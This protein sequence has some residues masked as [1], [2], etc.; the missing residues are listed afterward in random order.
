[1]LDSISKKFSMFL[2]VYVNISKINH[3]LTSFV[4]VSPTVWSFFPT[5]FSAW[6][7]FLF[8]FSFFFSF[9]DFLSIHFCH[10]TF[11]AH[12]PLLT[13]LSFL[14]LLCWKLGH[15][16]IRTYHSTLYILKVEAV[17]FV[18]NY[19]HLAYCL[20]HNTCSYICW[21]SEQKLDI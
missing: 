14:N 7:V 20:T 10:K 2:L 3:Q 12:A 1:M 6:I 13:R 9:K 15:R 17:P 8:S 5:A 18:C 16:L 4:N 19:W 21:I 11:L